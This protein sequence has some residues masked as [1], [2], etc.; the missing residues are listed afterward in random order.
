MLSVSVDHLEPYV[1]ATSAV[2]SGR[3]VLVPPAEPE[4]WLR[5]NARRTLEA[6]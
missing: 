3:K 6:E 1:L 2:R 4:A 5:R